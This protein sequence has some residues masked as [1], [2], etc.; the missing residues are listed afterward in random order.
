[1]PDEMFFIVFSRR[2]AAWNFAGSLFGGGERKRGGRGKGGFGVSSW[3]Q[4]RSGQRT[5][6][7]IRGKKGKRK[8]RATTTFAQSLSR[9]LRGNRSFLSGLEC[10]ADDKRRGGEK[11]KRKKGKRGNADVKSSHP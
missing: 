6:S 4:V 11:K 1:V 5:V 8:K 9:H 10:R 2:H 7:A 3:A